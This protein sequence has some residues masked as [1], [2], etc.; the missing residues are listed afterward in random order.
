VTDL[1]FGREQVSRRAVLQRSPLFAE[2][3]DHLLTVLLR[4]SD[5]VR[6]AAGTA[7]L[8][9]GGRVRCFYV[10]ATGLVTLSVEGD[11]VATLRA[12]GATIGL[13]AV[14]EN[15]P[16]AVTATAGDDTVLLAFRSDEFW[17]LLTGSA[18]LMRALLS[19]LVAMLVE[20]SR[21]DNTLEVNAAEEGQ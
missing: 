11:E 20:G 21:H 2:L 7:V 12:A 3:S 14:L 18:Q 19:R 6:P 13:S 9:E 8:A 1:V 5:V 16:S 10:L 4:R 17:S 15:H